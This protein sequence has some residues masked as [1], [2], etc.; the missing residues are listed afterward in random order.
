MDHNIGLVIRD[1]AINRIPVGSIEIMCFPVSG[2]KLESF[3][4]I[5]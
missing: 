2:L 4:G 5:M 3:I 1:T